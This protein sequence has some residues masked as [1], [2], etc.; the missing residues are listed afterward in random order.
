[1]ETL[2]LR[3][4][5]AAV[6]RPA[7]KS[8]IVVVGSPPCGTSEPILKAQPKACLRA[9]VAGALAAASL[10]LS[11]KIIVIGHRSS[12]PTRRAQLAVRLL[13][14]WTDAFLTGI[15]RTSHEAAVTAHGIPARL[16]AAHVGFVLT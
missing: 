7:V 9:A 4:T 16:D 13:M 11:Q 1:M 8:A 5:A 14:C 12:V 10:S 15:K 2:R 6:R 3:L